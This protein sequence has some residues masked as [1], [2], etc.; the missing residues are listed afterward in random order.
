MIHPNQ[1][2]EAAEFVQA[3]ALF[4]RDGALVGTAE[5]YVTDNDSEIKPGKRI[6]KELTTREAYDDVQVYVSGR[7]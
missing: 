2:K 7:R 4:F 1:G 3:R 6:R 5:V